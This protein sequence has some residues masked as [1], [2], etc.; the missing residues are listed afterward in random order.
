MEW[1]A[2]LAKANETQLKEIAGEGANAG[3]RNESSEKRN[4]GGGKRR[5]DDANGGRG[6]RPGQ[7]FVIRK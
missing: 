2:A 5:S 7:G 1:I 6:A 3:E 4:A